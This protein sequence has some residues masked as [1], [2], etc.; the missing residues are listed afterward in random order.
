MRD[1]NVHLEAPP[2]A[3]IIYGGTGQAKVVRP[4]IEER[5]ARVVAVFDDT[6]DLRSP[7]PDV[8]IYRGWDSFLRWIAERQRAE[9]GFCVAIGNPHGRARL[10]LHAQLKGEG[11]IPVSVIHSSASVAANASIGE[12]CQ[13]M[14]G[15]VVG[16]E[17]RLG[18]C[19]I[20][21]TRASVDHEDVLEDGAEVAPGATLCG[22]V[23]MEEASWVCA[24]ATVLP[25]LRIGADA[26]VGAGAVV[27]RD[28]VPRTTV[29]GVPARLM[30]TR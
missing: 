12:G 20:V 7:F 11:L 4:I 19:V 18:Q 3:V 17:A 25:R 29:V 8:P 10:R 21:N 9:L 5:G 28:V 14:A 2:P 24:G 16:V 15:A 22:A 6:P 23:R 26:I 13:I 30:K 27:T 1:G